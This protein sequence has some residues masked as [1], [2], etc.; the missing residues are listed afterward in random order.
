MGAA[1]W[2]D[3]GHVDRRGKSRAYRSLGV[4]CIAL[5][6]AS[7]SSAGQS[8]AHAPQ[9]A[10]SAVIYVARRGWHIDVGLAAADLMPPLNAVADRFP[11]SRYIFFGF[12]DRRYLAA[13]NHSAP[14]LLSALWPGAG[15]VLVTAL[16]QS[17]DEAF[18]SQHVIRLTL[19]AQQVRNLQ[20]FVWRTLEKNNDTLSMQS[21]GPYAYSLYFPATARYSAFHTCNTWVA[22]ALRAAGLRVR[23]AGVLFAAQLWSQV[24]RIQRTQEAAVHSAGPPRRAGPGGAAP[25]YAGRL[26][27][28]RPR[29]VLADHRSRRVRRY[30]D[31]GSGGRRRIAAADAA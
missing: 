3:V 6:W 7:N 18:G 20:E 19:H 8:A 31:S 17:P 2:A 24:R 1:I 27:A 12:G 11:D 28:G 15:I 14:V 21:E 22:Q 13:K 29:S 10:G 4:L 30:D 26:I 23:S 9:D 16:R 5:I 25:P